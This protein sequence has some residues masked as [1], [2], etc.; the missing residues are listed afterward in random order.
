MSESNRKTIYVAIAANF[1][2]AIVKF[3]VAALSGSSAMLSEGFH[4][5][6]DTG[7]ELLLLRGLSAANKVADESHPFGYGQELYFWTLIVAFGIFAVG[8]GISMYEGISHLLAPSEIV[9]PRWNYVVL[10]ISFLLEG[11][12]WQ[13]A[14]RELSTA[15]EDGTN[16]WQKIRR[17]KDPTVLSVFL[18]DSAALLGLIVA[19]LGIFL[20]TQLGNPYLDG[21]ASIVIGLLLIAVALLIGYESKELLIGEGTSA[22]TL[23]DIRTLA[24]NDSAVDRVERILTMHFGPREVLLNLDLQFQ[25]ELSAA[26]IARA[27]ERLENTIRDRH[28]E[29]EHI[30]VEAKSLGANL[31]QPSSN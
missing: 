19:F 3:V 6:V 23:G 1:S 27:I 4:S 15:S 11:Y 10:G 17:T 2:I 30:F 8:G 21:V 7:N 20:S 18:E 14:L 16:L 25:S 22:Q 12:S 28:P 31:I 9:D 24:E 13:L 5:L 29:I 26:E